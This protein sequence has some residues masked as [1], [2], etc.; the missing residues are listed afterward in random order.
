MVLAI[1]TTYLFNT[2]ST[3]KISSKLKISSL[4]PSESMILQLLNIKFP[5]IP[6]REAMEKYGTDK[7]DLRNP[8]I[9]QN[10]TDIFKREDVGFDI[11]KKLVKNGSVV[12]AIITK[13]KTITIFFI[14]FLMSINFNINVIFIKN[15]ISI[16][17]F[18]ILFF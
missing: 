1:L 18:F 10:I 9:I 5:R 4:H 14:N 15:M 13:K 11:F 3:D 16:N 7:P 17:L 6:F 8:L 12:K 2:F